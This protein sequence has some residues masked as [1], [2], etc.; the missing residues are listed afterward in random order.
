M[1]AIVMGNDKGLPPALEKK[2]RRLLLYARISTLAMLDSLSYGEHKQDGLPYQDLKYALGLEDGSL[3]PNLLWL[4]NKK[5]IISKDEK[6]EDKTIVVYYI[7][8]VGRR[9]YADVKAWLENWTKNKI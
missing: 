3:G 1:V 7:T 5:Y 9:A 6:I 2:L 8:D 4:K